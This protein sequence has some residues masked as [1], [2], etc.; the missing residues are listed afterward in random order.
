[1]LEQIATIKILGLVGYAFLFFVLVRSRMPLSLRIHFGLYLLGLGLWQFTSVMVTITTDPDRAIIWYNLQFSSLCLQSIIFFPLTRTF[2]QLK[3]QRVMTIVAYGVCAVTMSVGIAGR[4]TTHVV[5]GN[6]GYYIPLLG[7]TVYVISLVAYLFWGFGVFNLASALRREPL[8][9]QRSRIAYMLVGA[10]AVMLGLATNFTPLQAYP[11]D[12][13]CALIN[14]LLVSYAVTRYRLIETGTA[15][16]RSLAILLFAAAIV[17][18]YLLLSFAAALLIRPREPWR[19]DVAGLAGFIALTAVLIMV[20]WRYFRDF[21]DRVTGKKSVGYDRVLEQFS[22]KVRSLLDVDALQK[23]IVQTAAEPLGVDRG[24]L[25]FHDP[26]AQRYTVACT[27]GQTVPELSGFFLEVSDGFVQALKSLKSPLWEQE[28][29][30]DPNLGYIRSSAEPIFLRT[31]TAVA[32]PIIQE[33]DV[34]GILGLGNRAAGSLYSNEDMRFLSTLANMAASSLTVALN[35]ERIELQLS[36]Q[37]LL[38]VLSESLVRHVGTDQALRSAISVLKSFLDLEECTLVTLGDAEGPRLYS[39]HDLTPPQE[40]S[41]VSAAASLASGRGRLASGELF[42]HVA[43]HLYLPLT[44]ED[45]WVG[46]LVLNSADLER[47]ASGADAL[48]RAL[49]AILSQGLI[50]NRHIEEL[51]VLKE[52]NEKLLASIGASGEMLLI[53]APDGVILTTNSAACALLG[54]TEDELEG[55]AVERLVEGPPGRLFTADPV[56][57]REMKFVTKTGRAFPALV[58]SANIVGAGN[59]VQ[60]IVVLARDISRLRE[61]ERG[62]QES[63]GRYYSLFEGVL[64]AVVT[65]DLDGRLLDVNPAGRELFGII[66]RD[67][68]DEWNLARD[69]FA[70]P[71]AFRGLREQLAAKGSI[72]DHE[73]EL[74][75]RGG[76]SRIVLFSGGLAQDRSESGPIVHGIIHDVTEQRELQ[77]QLLQA[78]KMESVG[79]LAGGIAHDFNNILTATL[80]YAKLIREDIDDP[81]SVLAHLDIVEAS[82]HR[83][84]DLTRRLL[85]FSRAGIT[86]RNPVQINDIVLETIRLLRRSFDLSIEIIADCQDGLPAVLGDHG[87]IHQMLMNLCVNARDA[88]PDGG[89]LSLRTRAREAPPERFVMLEV[90]DTGSGIPADDIPRIYDPFFTTKAPGKGTGLG[91][92][93]VYG[94]VQRHG[95]RIQVSS[96]PGKGTTF[97]MLFPATDVNVIEAAASPLD[98]VPRGKET[99][100]IVDDEVDLRNLFRLSLGERGYTV[101][102]A[103]DGLEAVEKFRRR[104]GAIDLVLIDLIMPRLG[105]RETY[106]KLRELDPE[107]KALFATGYGIDDKVEDLLATGVLGIIRKPYELS[108]VEKE[109]RRVLDK[110]TR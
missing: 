106:M 75:I 84:V 95:G 37:T 48:L 31:G 74:R 13:A 32:I 44:R 42:F 52:Y 23:L 46:V 36:H 85:S 15:L 10:A 47:K 71:E 35:Y 98:A 65:F 58:S 79:T 89:T 92:S 77:R 96:V 64:D 51:R 90:S 4:A 109:I 12:N 27:Y 86:D 57:N 1:M 59:S 43:D 28:V 56:R 2:L 20:G 72:R 21:L 54:F 70:D 102:E 25:L 103:A 11:V 104:R 99:I 101:I 82:T 66:G 39:S 14:A 81:A 69:F 94:I 78:Q 87:Q 22:L 50:A 34:V 26:M 105:G 55:R 83:A 6:A 17:G 18:G 30:L 45:E 88:M 61:M 68:E 80:G 33:E 62:L 60:Q 49:R 108:A 91:L 41:L 24:F 19:V 100:M 29:L 40:I 7:T 110:P 73:I 3:K 38:F 8:A 16:K 9:L 76:R 97:E 53:T 107:V 67:D 5:L 93:I 63:E